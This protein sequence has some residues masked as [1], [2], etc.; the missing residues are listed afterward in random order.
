[1]IKSN[2]PTNYKYDKKNYDLFS[3][4]LMQLLYSLNAK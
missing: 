4:S 1:M 3:K 2:N